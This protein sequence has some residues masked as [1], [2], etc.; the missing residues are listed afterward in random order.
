VYLTIQTILNGL[1]NNGINNGDVIIKTRNEEI[2]C[3][4]F[5]L[6][7]TS[8]YLSQI[9]KDESFIGTIQLNVSVDVCNIVM[10]YLYTEII[11]D[12]KLTTDRIL[13]LITF[14]QQLKLFNYPVRLQQHYL[15]EFENLIDESNWLHLLNTIYNDTRYTDIQVKLFDYYYDVYLTTLNNLSI[16]QI[17]EQFLRIN[18]QLRNELFMDVLKKIRNE[19]IQKQE[20][21]K[22]MTKKHRVCDIVKELV[23]DTSDEE[24]VENRKKSKKM[25]SKK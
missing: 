21:S 20:N 18:E 15:C 13:E 14:V 22:I 19:I 25:I 23:E 16:Q 17:H 2:H 1:Y 6:E 8:E 11:V 12:K 10:N 3:H 9:V 4:K 24:T 5:V 7:S